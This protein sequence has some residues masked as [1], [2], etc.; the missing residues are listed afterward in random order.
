[1]KEGREVGIE[2]NID[3]KF[4]LSSFSLNATSGTGRETVAKN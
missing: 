4:R 1:M 2:A 3:N